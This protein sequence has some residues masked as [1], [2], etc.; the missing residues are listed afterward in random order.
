MRSNVTV[1]TDDDFEI[2]KSTKNVL[3]KLRDQ[4]NPSRCYT[5]VHKAVWDESL[6]GLS[7][8]YYSEDLN[9]IERKRLLEW[10]FPPI[11]AFDFLQRGYYIYDDDSYDGCGDFPPRF[12]IESITIREIPELIL[13]SETLDREL[14]QKGNITHGIS[15]P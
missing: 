13:Y 15:G 10:H 4:D 8:Q 11:L 3:I 2:L 6:P 12:T 1:L 5:I 9:D 14:E 7:S